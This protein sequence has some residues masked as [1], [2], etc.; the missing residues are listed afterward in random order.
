MTLNIT[1]PATAKGSGSEGATLLPGF[2]DFFAQTGLGVGDLPNGAGSLKAKEIR[3]V[4]G[5]LQ[6]GGQK[7]AAI[8]AGYSEGSA[9]QIASE[10]LRRPR[11]AAF[12]R[13]S[14]ERLGADTKGSVR[15]LEER[16]RMFHAKA[17]LAAAKV[18]AAQSEYERVSLAAG[19]D[20]DD[21]GL[22]AAA[23]VAARAVGEAK[24]DEARYARIAGECDKVLLSA[25]GKLSVG[26]N[27]S[28]RVDHTHRNAVPDAVID[29]VANAKGGFANGA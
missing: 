11:V 23:M 3:F 20:P 10:L 12:Y 21:K 17:S 22:A 26:V 2:G 27:V 25:A 7:R 18:D 14:L 16:A 8:E 19:A 5:V 15:R 29:F 9:D 13:Q 4:L 6:H 1:S 28:G 24:A